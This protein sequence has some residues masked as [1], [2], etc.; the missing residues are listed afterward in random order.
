MSTN[1]YAISDTHQNILM[2]IKIESNLNYTPIS[3][4]LYIYTL[5]YYV[6]L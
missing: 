4:L 3:K 6:A 5:G 1:I 2:L